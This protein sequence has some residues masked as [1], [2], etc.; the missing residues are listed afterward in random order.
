MNDRIDPIDPI[1]AAVATASILFGPT[2]SAIVGP[3]AVIILGATAGA[4]WALGRRNKGGKLG[5]A[6]FFLRINLTAVL[7]TVS[8]TKVVAQMFGIDEHAWLLGPVA[9]VIGGVGDDW[10]EVAQWAL[11]R[12]WE[13][14]T[15]G[16]RVSLDSQDK[17]S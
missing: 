8:L 11:R 1:T 2:M 16:K 15:G 7:L 9:F 6:W 12:A 14:R 17:E 5:A 3:Y 13:W 4:S 10:P